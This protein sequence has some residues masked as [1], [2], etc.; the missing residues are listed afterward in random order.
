[1]KLDFNVH[2]KKTHSWKSH[3]ELWNTCLDF[4]RK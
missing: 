2:L 4:I 1:M 3:A